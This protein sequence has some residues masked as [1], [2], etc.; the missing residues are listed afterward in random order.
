[1]VTSNRIKILIMCSIFISSLCYDRSTPANSDGKGDVIFLDRHSVYCNDG[2]ALTGFR[3]VRPSSSQISFKYSCIKTESISIEGE[4]TDYTSWY[5][6]ADDIFAQEESANRL[7]GIPFNC[8]N[9]YGLQGFRLETRCGKPICDLRFKYTCSPLKSKTC[10]SGETGWI[11]GED[12]QNYFLDRLWI[13]L[14]SYNVLTGFQ[15][16]VNYYFRI[17]QRDG[18]Y[19]KYSYNYC[20]LR[21][22]ENEKQIYDSNKDKTTNPTR[23]KNQ[24][25]LDFLSHSFDKKL[26]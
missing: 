11:N 16:R 7:S 3:L 5:P 14:D 21:N 18:R 9:D 26:D 12:G 23:V 6:A 25:E 17:F 4:Y 20:S 2:E 15:L 10:S 1:M 22:V 24:N 19:F 8:R 13:M